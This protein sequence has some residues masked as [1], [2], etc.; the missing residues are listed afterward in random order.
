MLMRL[1]RET[2]L[3]HVLSQGSGQEIFVE[4]FGPLVGLEA[5][6]RAQGASDAECALDA[7]DFCAVDYHSVADTAL[8]GDRPEHVEHEDDESRVFVDRLGRR[9]KLIKHSAS[10]PLPLDYPVKSMD[11]WLRI[12]HWLAYDDDRVDASCFRHIPA[13]RDQG[14]IAVLDM[15][16][17]FDLPRQLMGEEEACVAFIAEPELIEDM[18]QTA[19]DMVCAV[20]D[21][22]AER[23]PVDYLHVH[24]DFAG[25]SGP[26]IGPSMITTFFKPYYLRIWNRV[27]ELGGRVFSIDTDGY[28]NPVIDALLDAGINQ[29]YPMEP[30]AGMDIVSLRKKYGQRLIMKGGIDKHVLRKTKA[31]IRRELE[32]KL[33]PDMLGGGVVFGL[34][35]RIPNG[36]PIENYRYY[37]QTARE[38]LGLPPAHH[39]PGSWQ[40]MAF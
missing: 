26:L 5:E 14:A 3:N 4:M 19:G 20:L 12:K 15:P 38:L 9:M 25:K 8:R 10:I 11:D 36:T 6:W 13:L 34:D 29:I 39:R 16:G 27:Q 17:G 35:H 40:R 22:L 2:Y 30:A 24:E 33:Q 21:R 37:V 28:V 1:D 31:D 23:G 18:L 32:Y 7:F